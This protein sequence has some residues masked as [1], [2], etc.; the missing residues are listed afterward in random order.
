MASEF[1]KEQQSGLLSQ[2]R[3]YLHILLKWKWVSALFCAAAV[4]VAVI[5]SLLLTPLYTSSGSV[6][7]EGETNIL[8]VEDVESFGANSSLQSHARLLRSRALAAAVIKKLKLYENPDFA[9]KAKK[10]AAPR[11]PSD[12]TYNERLEQA[13]LGS[14]D[15]VS[16]QSTQLVDVRFSNRNPRLA[17]E[18]L[19]TLFDSYIEMIVQKRYA[20]SEK[21]AEFL[22][23]QITQLRTEIE[24]SERDLN[25]YGSE[26]DILPL[27][28][29]E[30]PTV[31]KLA[32]V[33]KALTDTIID[34]I[35]KLNAYNRLKAAPLGEIPSVPVGS[36]IQR[37]R[38]EYVNLNRQYA[39][40]LAT[41][42]PEFPA[43]QRLKSDLD[44]A[45]AALQ[46]E[47]ENLTRAAYSEYQAALIQ[48]QS[49][50]RLLETQKNEAY[51]ANSDSV[52]YNSLR[53]DLTSKKTLLAALS[54]RRSEIDV[55]S[56]EGLEGL[57][58][59]IVDKADYPLNPTSPNRRQNVLLGL[60]FG[61]VGGAGLALGL[62]YLNNTVKTSKD[63]A[64][65]I[66]IPTLGTIP[67]FDNGSAPKGPKPE[68]AR[69][70]AMF[71]GQNEPK[72][73]PLS[74]IRRKRPNRTFNS[75]LAVG[76]SGGEETE[77]D[78]IELIAKLKPRSIQAE[79]YRSIRTT[80]LVSSPPGRIK[81]ILLT[82]PLAREGKS[83]TVS[84][85][86]ITLAKAGKHVVIV[87]ADLRKPM[88]AR[89][90][91]V[92]SGSGL[93]LSQF[94]SSQIDT[95]D[96]VQPT[97]IENL[98][99]ITCGPVAGNPVELLTSDKMDTLVAKLRRD[100]D[101][102]LFDSP[103]LLAVSD[104][105]AM[106]PMADVIILVVRGD[107]TPIPALKQAK[108]KLDTHK[109]KCLGVILNDV[110]MID[111]DGFYAK[112]YYHYSK[113]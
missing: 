80:L 87:D 69:I 96:I 95:S 102:V 22:D 25:K 92:H 55:T 46:N 60:F 84:N 42:K 112:Q 71:R 2:I 57:N 52:V 18:I 109:L 74:S 49:L 106:G 61:L 82:S 30:A 4:A 90:F 14:L 47:T 34:R 68:I 50:R 111:Q 93:A 28:A 76:D 36:L 13:F 53:I 64:S 27:S 10:S 79:S 70:L 91:G 99:I 72:E 40:R 59:W 81:T 32:E 15:V 33:N 88:Q 48:E 9:G 113:G 3:H 65:A 29:T 8:P 35:N 21:A 6:W 103:P 11:D 16:V 78:R 89:I 108:M 7:I 105:L 94:L 43:M 66:G 41:V 77:Y 101:F 24:A 44:A 83:S 19:N 86:G 54:K 23:T 31:S 56:L 107:Q 39:S 38:E 63:V 51:S 17:S 37:L 100:F 12:P 58:V 5:Y 1:V 73:A 26:K 98:G 75:G 104:T 20:V 110:D 45:R 85:L 62:E 97:G 67:S